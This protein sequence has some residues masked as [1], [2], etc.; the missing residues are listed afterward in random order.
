MSV[1]TLSRLIESVRRSAQGL[2]GRLAGLF[3]LLALIPLAISAYLFLRNGQEVLEESIGLQLSSQAEH[4]TEN[5]DHLTAGGETLLKDWAKLPVMY[6]LTKGDADGRI[7]ETLKVLAHGQSVWTS[8]MIVSPDG[9]VVAANRSQRIGESVAGRAWFQ[10]RPDD[11]QLKWRPFYWTAKGGDYYLVVPIIREGKSRALIGYLSAY[12]S[13]AQLDDHVRIILSRLSGGTHRFVL[14]SDDKDGMLFLSQRETDQDPATAAG[15]LFS[16][17]W[18]QELQRSQVGMP[19]SLRKWAILTA[20]DGRQFLVGHAKVQGQQRVGGFVGVARPLDQAYEPIY[21]LRNQM[22]GIGFG[23]AAA[24]I[25]LA[26]VVAARLARPIDLLTSGAKAVASGNFAVGIL[27]TKRQDEI[28]SLA[29]A[30]D[31]MREDLHLLTLSL[32]QRVQA[33]TVELESANLQLQNQHAF[34]RQVLDINPGFICV[35]DQGGHFTLANQAVADA[36]G[37]SVESLIGKSDADFGLPADQVE[38]SRQDD[39]DVLSSGREKI[40]SE[41]AFTDAV[42]KVRWLQ[43]V[44][45]P[46]AAQRE[47]QNQVLGVS[48]DITALREAL[49]AVSVS[50]E[51]FHQMISQVKDY[52]LVMLDP[53]GLVVHWND[54]AKRITG[55]AA[56]DILG[57]HFSCFYPVEDIQAVVPAKLL[58]K[59][60]E[61]GSAE[62]ERWHLKQDG[63]KFWAHVAITPVRDEAGQLIGFSELTRDLTAQQESEQDK[64]LLEAQLRQAQKMEAVGRLAGGIAHDFNNLLT[65]ISGFSEMLLASLKPKDPMQP[66]VEE[67]IKAADRASKLTQ[68][69]L[70]FSRKQ[71]IQPIQLSLNDTVVN[72]E[73]MLRQLIGEDIWLE[74]VLADDLALVKADRGQIDQVIMNLVVNARDAMPKGGRLFLRTENV[75]I[76]PEQREPTGI[77]KPGRYVCLEVRD[78]GC[79]MDDATKARV[80]E[81]F[82]TTKEKGK[83]TGLGLATLYGIVKQS[84]GFVTVE[85]ELGRG[86]SFRIYLPAVQA[87]SQAKP[88][89]DGTHLIKPPRITKQATILLV[90][91][92]IGIR[93]LFHELLVSC[94]YKVLTAPDGEEG[95]AVGNSYNGP[96]DLLVTDVVMPNLSGAE[97]AQRLLGKYPQL[98]VLYMSGHADDSIVHHGVLE[99]G[100]AFLSKPFKPQVLVD[101]VQQILT[102]A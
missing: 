76:T 4:I 73:K 62:I 8:L 11:P 6:G 95:F 15:D 68:Q 96:I 72:I 10:N 47:G 101:R 9:K 98:K 79:G 102:A 39:L 35:K 80:F 51:R 90:E 66:A 5:L 31:H 99:P 33:R 27:P 74:S 41:E 20:K 94:G 7:T 36:Y 71:V 88:E 77:V 1:E 97:M 21:Q 86:A 49:Q 40:I 14:L 16:P 30:F 67:I 87:E 34:L 42:G 63:S 55:Y 37:V 53:D 82:F 78:T 17:D 22:L 83:G 84:D 60:I 29:R 54:G 3:L 70:A 46:L 85:S 81:P 18:S 93:Q 50:E 45:W 43:T 100:I 65:V 38:R 23:L 91:D 13:S 44:K 26:L 56:E 24:V 89:T 32:E 75:V 92:E 52:A 25:A 12:L 69:L 58:A 61:Q 28:G 57:R 2:S 59:A 48:V 64:A 19:A